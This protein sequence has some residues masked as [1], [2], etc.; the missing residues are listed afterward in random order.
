MAGLDLARMARLP[1]TTGMP[2]QVVIQKPHRNDYDHAFRATG[3]TL[4]EVG[5][6]NRVWE[7]ELEEALT[8]RTAAVAYVATEARGALPLDRVAA[9]A[10][11]RGIP[12]VVDA[13]A[14]LPPT[15][16]LRRFIAEG[17]DLVAFSGGKALRGPQASGILAGRRDLIQSVALQHQDMDVRPETW[18]YQQRYLETGLL[19]GV[20]YHGVGRPMKV[21]KEE[22]VG[23]VVALRLFLDRDEAAEWA[24]WEAKVARLV[25]GMA[26]VPGVAAR[27][28]LMPDSKGRAPVA[29]VSLDPEVLGLTAWEVINRLQAKDPRILLRE[30]HAD[31]GLLVL[32]PLSLREG[33]ETVIVE[34]L[35]E[36]LDIR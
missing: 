25:E 23:L 30:S 34:R 32:H 7:W 31:Q 19:P 17:A 12:V 33:E 2:D 24:D 16:S 10:Q 5:F 9:I 26:G 22:I 29:E 11:S 14:A 35:R 1:D 20:P 27:R 4:V 6:A 15:A 21:G 3:A 28:G 36:V 8:E 18:S 13:A